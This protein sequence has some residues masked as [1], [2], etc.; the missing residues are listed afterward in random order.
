M[1]SE[2]EK[3]EEAESE[4]YDSSEVP[5][6]EIVA[7]NESRSCADLFRM[8]NNKQ[9]VIEP[10]FQRNYIWS[11]PDKT[12]FIDSL[13]KQLPIP[14]ICISLDF[15]SQKRL[16]IDGLQ[17]IR[18]IIEFLDVNNKFKL[19]VLKDIDERISGKTNQQIKEKYD[20]LFDRVENLTISVTVVRSDYSK[21]NHMNYLFTIFHRLNT[22]GVK[23]NNQEIRNCIFYGKFNDLLKKLA[24]DENFLKIYKLPPGAKYRFQYEEKILRF[25]A[26]SKLFETY[27]GRLAKFLNDFMDSN[28]EINEKDFDLMKREF[29][30]IHKL[31]ADKIEFPKNFRSSS[32]AIHE[33]L[34]VGIQ[35]NYQSCINKTSDELNNNFNNLIEDQLFLSDSLK[36][37]LSQREKVITRLNRSIEIF[38]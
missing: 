25:L 36:E 30:K 3:L 32:K 4:E 29:I 16:V 14:S 19:S 12:R 33:A 34:Y 15:K 35:K 31:I 2:L 5:P 26:F 38:K 21:P 13:I 37:G 8:A 22:G 10:D 9:L 18:T 24:K 17:R 27:N 7:Y 23:L 6:A 20:D 11:N 1:D 28:K